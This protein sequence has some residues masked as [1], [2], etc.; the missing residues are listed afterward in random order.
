MKNIKKA[1]VT[2]LLDIM[3]QQKMPLT[4]VSKLSWTA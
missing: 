4:L 3:A 1:L 2:T